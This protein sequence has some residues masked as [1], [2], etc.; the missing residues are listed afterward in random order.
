[1]CG[2]AG[3]WSPEPIDFETKIRRMIGAIAHRG[4]DSDGVT[5]FSDVG[6]A[7]GH[8]RLA[9]VD[10]SDAGH[11]PMTSACQRYCI[12]YNGEIYNHRE[13][14]GEL[15]SAGSAP[16]WRGESDTETLLA[17]VSAWGIKKTLSRLNGMFAFAIW[18]HLSR[19]LTLA[20]DRFGEKPLYYGYSGG[21]FVFASELRAIKAGLDQTPNLDL[22]SVSQFLRYSSIPAPRS[23]YER[24]LKLESAHYVTFSSPDS[25]GEPA[26]FWD[27][28]EI[29]VAQQSE[30]STVPD[31]TT[32]TES[33]D[34][35]H[36]L[37]R[38]AVGARLMSDVPLGAFLSGGIDSSLVVALM[39]EHLGTRVNTFTIGFEEKSHDESEYARA[40]ADHLGTNHT[41][42]TVTSREAQD[43]IPNIA[44][45]WDE[46]F[47][48]SSQIPT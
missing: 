19:S 47:S 13:I 43:V 3:V 33:V 21:R 38:T 23:V 44:E 45:Y 29:A 16:N 20:R 24:I 7:L 10:L 22:T 37:L 46:P 11:Q 36:G 25:V 12:V 14:R 40:V 32:Y 2:I 4:P 34:S 17:A 15:Q 31:H 8:K 30:V 41:E 35:L 6:L 42:K 39:Q 9:I 5:I 26:C 48:D 1:M 27:A 28:N 18:D